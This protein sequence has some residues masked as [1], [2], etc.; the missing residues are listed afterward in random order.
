MGDYFSVVRN[1]ASR[2]C[3]YLA[4]TSSG[5]KIQGIFGAIAENTCI[6][7]FHVLYIRLRLVTAAFP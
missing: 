3:T 5:L 1:R 4:Y 2:G 7:A 6:A